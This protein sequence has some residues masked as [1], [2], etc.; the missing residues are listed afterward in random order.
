MY[1]AESKLHMLSAT[2]RSRMWDANADGYARGEGFAS[3]VL[4][5]LSSAIQ[6]GDRIECIIRETGV[7]QDGRTT[8]ITM[9]S[10]IAQTALIK[11]TYAKAGLDIEKLHDRP[12][13]FH[14]HGTGTPAGD[15]QEA[16]AI[17]RAFPRLVEEGTS[18]L[19]VGSIKTVIGHTEGTAGLASLIGSS[20][21]IQ[22]KVIPPNMHFDNLSES[23]APFY[24]GLEI[25]KD[26]RRWP[27]VPPGQPLRAS[28]NSF[29]FGGT[30][31]HAIVESYECG[32]KYTTKVPLF[33]PLT[34]SAASER[35]L[36]ALLVSYSEYLSM[37][38]ELDLRNLAWTLQSRRSALP[39]R[40]SV[41]GSTI[42]DLCS[43]IDSKLRQYED[44]ETDIGIHAPNQSNARILGV[45]T[46]QGAQW[47]TMGRELIRNSPYVRELVE[48]LDRSL[49]ELP[50]DSRPSWSIKGELCADAST[51]GIGNASLS[52]PL[53]TA[54]QIVLVHLLRCAGIQLKAVV[55]HSSGEIGAAYAA[56]FISASD[57]IRI[58]YYRGFH[59]ELARSRNGKKG[60]MMAVGTTLEDARAFCDLEDFQGRLAVAAS[61][62]S[63]SITLSGDEDAID[64]AME[65]FNDEQ[66]FARRLKVDT[67][68]HSFHMEPCAM[69]YLASISHSTNRVETANGIA[70]F[71]SVLPGQRMTVAAR[72]DNYWVDNM[73]NPV[74]FSGAV[75]AAVS[76]IGSF[77]ISIE[78]GPHPA[79]KGPCLECLEEASGT[80]E[81]PYSGLLSRGRN[82]VEAVST[83]LGFLW[84]HLGPSHVDFDTY[85]RQVSGSAEPR[86]LTV[87]LPSYPWD[88]QRSY[89]SDSRI[90][91]SFR[92]HEV[93]PHP[94][95]GTR[96]TE[97]ITPQ[98]IQWRNLLR[99]KEIPWLDGHKLQG[100]IVFPASG[101][102]TMAV[103]AAMGL[104]ENYTV[105]LVEI[106][107]LIIGRAMAFHDDS[108]TVETLLSLE[109]AGST[110]ESSHSGRL[111]AKFRSYSCPQG[112]RSMSLNA[113]GQVV[114]QYG[115]TKQD[116][117][118]SVLS[119]PMN[120]VN[121]DI[122]RFYTN[123]DRLGYNYS[124]P[125]R[126][127]T[128]LKRRVDSAMGTLVNPPGIGWEDD[129]LIHPGML[130]TAFQT[131]FAAYC[132][133][134]DNRLW[135]L[136]VP[137]SIGRI[138]INPHHYATS[139]R[140]GTALPFQSAMSSDARDAI[141]ADVDIFCE[142]GQYPFIQ[143]ES[144]KLVPFAQAS[145][146]NDSVLFSKFVW[147]VACPDGELAAQ[148]ELPTRYERL[149]AH[150]LERVCFYYLRSLAETITPKEKSDTLWHYRCLLE[151]ASHVSAR[152]N[153][154]KH[155]YLQ[156]EW[157]HD[158]HDEILGLIERYS[159]RVDVRLIKAVGENLPQ[160]IR[161]R[162]NILEHMA[163][164][165]LLSDFY[166]QGLGLT[167][168]NRW[169]SRIVRQIAHRYPHMNILEIGAG[170]GG[171]TKA[172]LGELRNAF[173]SYTYTDISSG[174]FKTARERF[175][176]YA[177]KMVF[178]TFDIEKSVTAQGFTQGSYDLIVA[179]N[180]LHATKTLEETMRN[181]HQ[182]LK[183]GATLVLLE[184]T[185][186]EPIRNGL[187]MGGLTGW[188]VGADSG[189]PWGRT[190]SHQQW[191][192]LLRKTGF[193]GVDT[194]TPDYD[195]L[196]FP[197]SVFTTQAVD[198]R[199]SYLRK[200]LSA[201]PQTVVNEMGH[202]VIIGGRILQTSRMVD[203]LAE[204]LAQRYNT[205]TVL[206]TVEKVQQSPIPAASTVL[207]LT[208][209]DE[210]IL[211]EFTAQKLDTLKVLFSQARNILWVTRGCRAKDPYSN[212]MVGIGRAVR[213][214]YPNINLQMFDVDHLSAESSQA[215]AEN[216]LRLE[217]LNIWRKE[218]P[219][220][221][222]LYSS[223]PEIALEGGSQIIPRL[224]PNE[225]QNKRY[226]SS[227]RLITRDVNPTESAVEV[228][229][230]AP[231]ELRD[232]SW[233]KP[234][235][236]VDIS[237]IVTIQV[238][239]SLL[240][241]VR[242]ESAGY[243]CLC[244][245]SVVDSGQSVL[246]LSD[247]NR[248]IVHVP[249]EL[250]IACNSG[251]DA[252]KIL[253]SVT[254][255]LFAG[256]VTS[257]IP[258]GGTL[259]VH[260]PDSFLVSALAR[261]AAHK[262][263]A[264][265]CTTS[266]SELRGP[267]WIH[268]HP[269]S[270]NRLIKLAIPSNASLFMNF[271]KHCNVS[272]IG[273]RISKILPSHCMREDAI[274][275]FSSCPMGRFESSLPGIRDLLQTAWADSEVSDF[276]IDAAET[277][278]THSLADIPQTDVGNAVSILDW[279]SDPV[280]PVKVQP[281]DSEDLFRPDR[282]YLLVGLSGE[283][284]RSL[285]QWMVQ[286][287]A[288]YVVLTSRNPK[289]S[290]DWI[291]SFT[292]CGATVKIMSM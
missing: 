177:G 113:T 246:A 2:G 164:D 140:E 46:G 260:E 206:D 263:I 47:A 196:V 149:V 130:D 243:F 111:D 266:K 83:A 265:L 159:D 99:K 60:A 55:G 107:D 32:E 211:K 151:W 234:W 24:D 289:V 6:D 262:E 66:K 191:D 16:E 139:R 236:Q 199:V 11:E 76:E 56:G 172:I 247:T 252:L 157:Q 61:N 108:S 288:R 29:G 96:C 80:V 35:A 291:D 274:S 197:F 127:I 257:V 78:I 232:A 182:L 43:G 116:L 167:A 89:W 223:E 226:N 123:L 34:F 21:A 25:C 220:Y 153:S 290:H 238:S 57:A 273:T 10:N 4:K 53:C 254:S 155:P 175:R 144:V 228:V 114:L 283:L 95:L 87:D 225:E 278:M 82:D 138:S 179:S 261:R 134:G 52:Q 208:D 51:S 189:R 162:S 145:P 143:I 31:A 178:K 146:E 71:S 131:I 287:G 279:R 101:Y 41:S 216:L 94:L 270:T 213:F 115:V 91:G 251:S 180:V 58:A 88:R 27:F 259:V 125:F 105:A 109:L 183:P 40:T 241:T 281:I 258:T 221:N 20:L 97:S 33:T 248:S 75:T 282:T 174:F 210:P 74:M 59:A 120:M 141:S 186:S 110:L 207:S 14:A 90:S 237:D 135:S 84:A 28:V 198:D 54:V 86:E 102:V 253:L 92:T 81:T 235:P 256:Y 133:P 214:E 222:I 202:L 30:N 239:H 129:I 126:G 69:P 276:K 275:F 73:T 284:G 137:T 230:G 218:D 136:H 1:I 49:A 112:E 193:S 17:S 44:D 209:L 106:R 118:P 15:P 62:S 249:K 215:V 85:D 132:S 148:S 3:V 201:L 205:T 165:G 192:S 272:D 93:G 168:S 124:Y 22:H 169:I 38:N 188:W 185:N 187:P 19:Y 154:G 161:D 77:D 104:V 119:K 277:V 156:R 64:Q 267:S 12:Q 280:V 122:E 98:E 158:T 67:A 72:T 173:T 204:I 219:L 18:K 171:A 39:F 285:C 142:S 190:L 264:L 292:S 100:Q 200:P 286:H 181:T 50:E 23:V 203:D 117:L 224:F 68:Y 166:E 121:V 147:D 150:D 271:D 8:G 5:R 103:E 245:G 268:I 128:S 229:A 255:N 79:L 65:V 176:D 26:A 42:E 269:H 48:M 231:C 212:M 7:N 63:A 160:V 244:L 70:W 152:A 227:R 217:A 37:T 184:V 45:F 240:Q 36:R 13:F 9:P 163:Q 194:T 233:R 242:F 195:S 250:A 170:T